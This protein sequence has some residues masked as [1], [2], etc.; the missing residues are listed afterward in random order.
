M[1]KF[2]DERFEKDEFIY[3]ENPNSFFKSEFKKLRNSGHALFPLEGEG[4]NACYA[5]LHG[6]EVDAFDFSEAGKEKSNQ[7]CNKHNVSVNYDISTAE[8]YDFKDNKYDL[9]VLIYAHLNPEVRKGF[10]HNIM[11]T[12]KPGGKLIL[13]AFHPKQLSHHYTSGGPKNEEMLYTLEMLK[14][15]FRGMSK[16]E[17]E[18]CEIELNEGKHHEGK[19]FVTRLR[20][21]K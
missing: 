16:L 3:G 11:K 10:H 18:E 5:T 1:K 21:V 9:V 6:W 4:R 15:D 17:G 19:G 14:Q 12:L 8:G 20:G 7:L 2:W 13:E